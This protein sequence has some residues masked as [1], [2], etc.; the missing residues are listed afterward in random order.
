MSHLF[1]FSFTFDHIDMRINI[2]QCEPVANA[3]RSINPH[4][5]HKR[6][7]LEKKRNKE[8]SKFKMVLLLRILLN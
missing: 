4:P 5:I 3:K 8:E 6:S 2:I 1:N 7:Q